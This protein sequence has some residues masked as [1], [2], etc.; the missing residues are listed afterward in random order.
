MG[1]TLRELIYDFGG[2][3]PDGRQLKAVIPGGSSVPVLTA[4]QIDV[5]LDADFDGRGRLDAR[6]GRDH[7]HRRPLLHGPARPSRRAVLH[8]R[9]LRQVHAVPRGHALDGADPASRSRTGRHREGDLDLLLDVC[10]RILGKCLCPLGDAAAMP[11]ASY[12]DQFR[13]EFQE[14]LESGCPMHGS[15]RSRTFSRPSTSTPP[16]GR[17]G[18]RVSAGPRRSPSR[19]T[20]ARSRSPRGPGSSRPRPRRGSRSPSSAT[21]PGSDRPSAPAACAS[22]RSRGCPSSRRAA[23]WP[24]RTGWSSARPQ[25]SAKAAEG[26]NATLEFILVNHPLDCPVCDKGGECPL[27]D[28]T[29]KYG[30]GP[31]AD[32]VSEADVRQADP[33]LADDRARP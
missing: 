5:P 16:P 13:D 8:A 21:S 10:D 22:S 25:S 23:P 9:E 2:G 26:Q 27:Q 14:H 30:P 20:A 7:R 1:V 11:V 17:R 19:S 29:F 32:D 4:D 28:L 3:I 24:R 12:I 15:R 18:A 31:H 33:D 6:L